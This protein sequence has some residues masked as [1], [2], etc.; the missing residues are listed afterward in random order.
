MT[1]PAPL[2]LPRPLEP[3]RPWL[4]LLGPDLAEPVGALLLQLH[5]LV[6]R[7]RAAAPSPDAVPA[8]VGSIVQRGSY[9]RLLI[10]EWAYADAA[11][12]E[13]IRR[14]AGNELLFTGPEP[15]RQR[16][17]QRSIALFDA[18][19]AQLGE[20]RLAQLA[21]FI[22]LARRAEDA[23]AQFEWGVLQCPGTLH[24]DSG[25]RA[26]RALLDARTLLRVDGADV[27]A[28]E[29][30]CAAHDP[31]D[32]AEYWQL[33]AAG[34][35]RLVQARAHVTIEP[36]LL[37]DD[38]LDLVL[39][40]QRT[41]RK[42]VLALPEPATGVR[43]LRHP[44]GNA[45]A[46]PLRSRIATSTQLRP[47]ALQPPR[48][49]TA[50]PYVAAARLGGGIITYHVPS[51]S[52]A[53]PARPRAQADEANGSLLGVA[54]LKKS[55][56]TVTARGDKIVFQHFPGELFRHGFTAERP[57][58]GQFHA[59]TGGGR[60][61][62]TF[63]L[64]Q[65]GAA[66]IVKRILM[67]DIARRLVCWEWSA[68][69]RP[70]VSFSVVA[71]DVAGV[72]QFGSTLV[73]ANASAAGIAVFHWHMGETSPYQVKAR[74]ID[75]TC[76]RVAFGGQV[77]GKHGYVGLLAW[78][79][80]SG[81]WRVRSAGDKV[82]PVVIDLSDGASVIGVATVADAENAAVTRDGLVVL[83]R[84]KLSIRLY[85]GAETVM[86]VRSELAIAQAALD[87]RGERLAWIVDGNHE[88]CVR[89][90]SKG[91]TLLRAVSEGGAD[92]A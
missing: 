91:Q 24:Q 8:G 14:A 89:H 71:K 45:E 23:G 20:P 74:P 18:G 80:V 56:G 7:M 51:S 31:V 88:F 59:P 47:S 9:D 41:V 67:L 16:R 1:T 6:G 21:L 78:Q 25:Q 12:D 79:T 35:P 62:P 76:A 26:I 13:F 57:P 17:S 82:E 40:Q 60:W 52:A 66:D 33:G 27:A 5:P 81:T 68:G 42:L 54:V 58:M 69:A 44:F 15:I 48:F 28:W 63:F 39:H 84:D 85:T 11:P 55:C 22:L 83:A 34:A 32:D 4:A 3:W 36:N 53:A 65:G 72:A 50:G 30:W 87:P 46:A 2:S 73:Y 64:A 75:G 77:W 19:P 70:Q 38:R 86:L 90:L 92:A 43:L 61:L 10:S 29:G 37:D 49:G